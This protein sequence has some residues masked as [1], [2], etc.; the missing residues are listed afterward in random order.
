MVHGVASRLCNQ[1][2]LCLRLD[3][4]HANLKLEKKKITHNIIVSSQTARASDLTWGNRGGSNGLDISEKALERAQ[5]GSMLAW[6]LILTNI[7]IS[8]VVIWRMQNHGLAF[9]MFVLTYTLI[10]SVPFVFSF[11][12]IVMRCFGCCAGDSWSTH[13]DIDDAARENT[14]QMLFGDMS[15]FTIMRTPEYGD[16]EKKKKKP[17]DGN[18]TPN[19]NGTGDEETIPDVYSDKGGDEVHDDGS[20]NKG[21]SGEDNDANSY[22]PPSSVVIDTNQIEVEKRSSF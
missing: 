14:G 2:V 12:E 16:G 8:A 15:D 21:G 1:Y 20:N 22:R 9:S 18:K 7:L 19:A 6:S 4:G 11:I 17:W 3:D 5:R 10:L 13:P